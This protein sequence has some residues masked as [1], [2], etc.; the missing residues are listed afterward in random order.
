MKNEVYFQDYKKPTGSPENGTNVVYLGEEKIK[1]VVVF[2]E[3][4]TNWSIDLDDDFFS[5]EIS[6]ISPSKKSAGSVYIKDLPINESS[7]FGEHYIT[8]FFNYTNEENEIITNEYKF[9][10][11]YLNTLYIKEIVLPTYNSKIFQ[12]HIETFINFSRIQFLFDSDGDIEI[13]NPEQ[14]LLSPIPGN[15]TIE[16]GIT[17]RSSR[18]GN[19][20]E[21]GYHIIG[22][23][24][25]RTVEFKENNIGISLNWI[26]INSD[27]VFNNVT[28][29]LLIT[30]VIIAIIFNYKYHFKQE[31]K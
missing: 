4:C 29:M 12:L 19:S 1:L 6:G 20:Q 28:Y 30:I 16:T 22:Y 8:L 17:K 27:E 9:I 13:I 25:N 15:Y 11:N 26:S 14:E 7:I 18:P 3:N 23:T 24:G 31:R 10:L 21:V 2:G 5:T